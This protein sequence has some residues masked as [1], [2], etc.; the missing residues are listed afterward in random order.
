MKEKKKRKKQRKSS[1]SSS[2]ENSSPPLSSDSESEGSQD[3]PQIRSTINVVGKN[4]KAQDQRKNKSEQPRRK[5]QES[6]DVDD[7]PKEDK[8]RKKRPRS[9]SSEEAVRKDKESRSQ[10]ENNAYKQLYDHQRSREANDRYC[11]ETRDF[12]RL[13]PI[14]YE[15]RRRQNEKDN[16]SLTLPRR[17]KTKKR[18]LKSKNSSDDAIG[19]R[20]PERRKEWKDRKKDERRNSFL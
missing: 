5:K 8:S 7:P 1:S 18:S 13:T 2:S 10:R 4:L 14:E 6:S 12:D 11:R 3:F 20:G 15:N 9:S 19:K 16:R 17:E